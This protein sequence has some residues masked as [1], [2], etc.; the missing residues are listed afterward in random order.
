[1]EKIKLAIASDHAGFGLKCA[2]MEWLEAENYAVTDLGTNTQESVDYPD[3][4]HKLAQAIEANEAQFGIGICGTGAGICMTLNKHEKIRA[5]VCWNTDIAELT[6]QHNNANVC[7]LPGRFFHPEY[8]VRII[9][10]FLY[11][12]FE[13][14]RHQRRVEKIPCR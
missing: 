13:G 5:A 3:F 11:T 8:A 10:K 12:S 7:V 14:G 9:S 6:R 2:I 1:M 4:G